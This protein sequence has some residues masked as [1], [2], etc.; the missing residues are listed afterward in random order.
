LTDLTVVNVALPN[1]QRSLDSTFSDLQ[2]VI[3]AYALTLAAFL[4]TSGSLADRVG[5]RRV[6]LVGLQIFTVASVL[7]G[8]ATS[9]LILNVARAVEGIGGAVMYAV[10]PAMIANDF[11]GR[12]R[13]LAFGISGGV[14]GLAVAIG[15]LLGGALTAISW[16]WVFLL[17]IPVGI[18]VTIVLL[19]RVSESRDP[20]R[21]G[22]DWAGLVV[23]STALTLLV[24]ALIRGESAGWT[25]A[26][27]VGS[28]AASVILLAAFV[29]IE[30]AHH[31][32]MFDLGLFRN[33]SFNGLSSPTLAV[34]AAL[35]VAI[36]FQVLYMQYALGFDAF[37]T[38]LRYLPLTL[39]VF[40]A[41]AV[42]G[43]LSAQIPARLL[44]GGGSI[45]MGVGLIVT[46]NIAI[47]SAW[48]H[49]LPGM[50]LA[51][52][53]MGLFNPARAA[54]AV[55]LVPLRQA[56]MSSG[57][58]ETFQQTGVAL[59][60]AAI[61]SAAHARL[62]GSFSTLIASRG[63]TPDQAHQ[64]GRPPRRGSG[65]ARLDPSARDRVQAAGTA[66]AAVP[67]H[68]HLAARLRRT[69][70]ERGRRAHRPHHQRGRQRRPP[71]RRRLARAS[72][73][74]TGHTPAQA[75]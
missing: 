29:F 63:A 64:R 67:G 51:G 8:L 23:F 28:L 22:V 32:P 53:G 16:R 21:R 30:R 7:C 70:R 44:L 9:P 11:H 54:T 4:L 10:A 66:R 6:F 73:R 52:V 5:R 35:N 1:I 38:G 26:Q 75:G 45:V 65:A 3:D 43:T 47:A 25:S 50:L 18:A 56:G 27:I 17:N 19:A 37:A 71:R 2:W 61:G 39:A 46:G 72:R 49:L 60:V 68:R 59:G 24:F 62:S 20:S 33:R 58:S 74:G 57:I 48:T 40:L 42:A 55:A 34:N 12:Q 14:T 31:E 36:L 69:G 15:P 13:G 41:A